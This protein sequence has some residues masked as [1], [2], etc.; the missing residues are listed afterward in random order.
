MVNGVDFGATLDLGALIALLTP[1]VWRCIPY[2]TTN[3]RLGEVC[4]EF[5]LLEMFSR[6]IALIM[7][8]EIRTID[9]R[10]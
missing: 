8:V 1:R 2:S 5:G 10:P 6:L 4:D 7:V 9:N 3:P